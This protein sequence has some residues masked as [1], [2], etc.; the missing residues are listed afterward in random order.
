MSKLALELITEAKRTN[1][2]VL[3][4]GYCGLTELPDELFELKE[5]EELIVSNGHRDFKTNILNAKT[6]V[7]SIN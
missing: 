4:L 1:A 2:K 5:L 6:K 3:D 7:K